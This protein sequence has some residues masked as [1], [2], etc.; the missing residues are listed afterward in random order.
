MCAV[1]GV[2]EQNKGGERRMSSPKVQLM[3]VGAIRLAIGCW[4]LVEVI[5]DE[6]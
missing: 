4:T 1:L 3:G 5:F 6:R 2:D